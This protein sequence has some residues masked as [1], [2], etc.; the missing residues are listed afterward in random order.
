[1]IIFQSSISQSTFPRAWKQ[2]KIVPIHKGGITT[3]VENYRPISLTSTCSKLLEHI[4]SK[5][6]SRY[7]ET[8]NLLS[9]TQHGFRKGLSTVAQLVE[10]VH[11]LS[12]TINN[13]GQIDLIKKKFSKAFD[14]VSHPKLLLKIQA[15]FKNSNITNW[16]KSYLQSRGQFVE[17]DGCKSG[18][19]PVMS[20][21]PQGSVLGPLLF[22]LFINDLANS[23]TVPVRLFADDCVLYNRITSL[24]DQPKLQA[25]LQKIVEWCDQWQ[26]L[27][28]E[29]S[30]SMSITRERVTHANS[31]KICDI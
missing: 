2:A 25:S 12:E 22:I 7:L 26:I 15:F 31:Y 27:N 3:N 28:P 24:D 4:I 16:L 6:L 18:F 23:A 19:V 20:G 17:L 30:V 9:P 1:M 10:L 8:Y 5:H 14:K 21:V 29:K 13:R 11:N